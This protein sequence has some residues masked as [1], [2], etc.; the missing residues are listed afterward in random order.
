M[1]T[2]HD[3]I[4]NLLTTLFEGARPD[5]TLED[6]LVAAFRATRPTLVIHP[7]VR[8]AA[9]GVAA[10]ILLGGAGFTVTRV[11]QQKVVERQKFSDNTR[12]NRA[13]STVLFDDG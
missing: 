9:V 8:K 5:G 10:A 4:D 2:T 11:E 7:M 1:T 12:G 3:E 6:R 13:Q